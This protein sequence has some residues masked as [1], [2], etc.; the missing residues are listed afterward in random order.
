M[1]K[2][3]SIYNTKDPK[4]N[5]RGESTTRL[6][7][8]TDAVFGIAITLLIFNISDVTTLEALLEF[9]KSFPALLLGIV[10]LLIIWDEHVSFSK[11]YSTQNQMVKILNVFFIALV[12]FYVYPLKFLL[13][14]IT[15]LFFSNSNQIITESNEIPLLMI[16][17]GLVIFFIYIVIYL[18]YL[19]VLK[20]KDRYSLTN[21]EL[22]YTKFQAKRITIMYLVPL[23][24]I[25]VTTVFLKASVGLSALFGG[26]TYFLYP[27]LIPVWSNQFKKEKMRLS[28]I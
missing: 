14:L 19:S 23:I 16:Y 27:I 7:N 15:S 13:N 11:V 22:L 3:H 17:Y 8:L 4:L 2:I 6:D 12:I 1:R 26:I 25:V 24:S 10:F 9:A 18:F 5:Y 20:Q 28:K 21:Y